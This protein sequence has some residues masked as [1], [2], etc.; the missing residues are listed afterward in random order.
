M[1]ILSKLWNP[2]SGAVKDQRSEAKLHRSAAMEI[3]DHTVKKKALHEE[4]YH[5]Q[6]RLSDELRR[7]QRRNHFGDLFQTAVPLKNQNRS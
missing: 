7:E 4:I 2:F 5:E 1:S 6:K 3:F